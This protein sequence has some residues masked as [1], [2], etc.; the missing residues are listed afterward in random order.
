M[1][2]RAFQLNPE[3]LAHSI[4]SAISLCL[5]A[6]V[7]LYF[8]Y[9][10]YWWAMFAAFVAIQPNIGQSVKMAIGRFLGTW[11]GIAIALMIYTTYN[12]N[13]LY[14][15]LLITVIGSIIY[16]VV[17]PQ[18]SWPSALCLINTLNILLLGIHAQHG[19]AH[20]A[21]ERGLEV[22]L[23][24]TVATVVLIVLR[25]RYAH[26]T[27]Q[28]MTPKLLRHY[29]SIFTDIT[30]PYLHQGT[31]SRLYS[32]QRRLNSCTQ[33][34][35]YLMTQVE[36]SRFEVR[37]KNFN[38]KHALHLLHQ[39][40]R[41]HT[42]LSALRHAGEYYRVSDCTIQ[43]H[44]R[45]VLT[46][47]KALVNAKLLRCQQ[48]LTSNQTSV[49]TAPTPPIQRRATTLIRLNIARL[50]QRQDPKL[51]DRIAWLSIILRLI[52]QLDETEQMIIK[53][54]LSGNHDEPQVSLKQEFGGLVDCQTS[55]WFAWSKERA[56]YAC[57]AALT[58]TIVLLL[59]QH[60]QWSAMIPVIAAI[61]IMLTLIS[62]FNT[63][64]ANMG[65]GIAGAIAGGLYS[66]LTL[67]ILNHYP[68][69]T[70]LL[71]S[72]F[73]ATM[74]ASYCQI[75]AQLDSKPNMV[76]A[77]FFIMI[78][79]IILFQ[80]PSQRTDLD[81]II[82]M[83]FA[84]ILSVIVLA[85][86]S[87]W[88][89]PFSYKAAYKQCI[90]QQLTDSQTVLRKLTDG[91]I[92]HT[93]SDNVLSALRSNLNIADHHLTHLNWQHQ[94]QSRIHSRGRHI[95]DYCESLIYT[96]L[97]MQ[98]FYFRDSD[99]KTSIA[100][101]WQVMEPITQ[102]MLSNFS[103]LNESMQELDSQHNFIATL[104]Q[105]YLEQLQSY[106]DS[107]DIQPLNFDSV[108]VLSI[109]HLGM[110]RLINTQLALHGAIQP[111]SNYVS[112]QASSA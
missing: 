51:L 27:I 61:S 17:R 59:Q 100:G 108:I 6:C 18:I 70:L 10:D 23:A 30:D 85:T 39:F 21:L 110:R 72:L 97:M 88:I 42:I 76:F 44:D 68:Q 25:F 3:Y 24:I 107:G 98:V 101:Y 84:A 40:R 65:I 1:N 74:I 109:M 28:Q 69:G 35:N 15:P 79:T 46:E 53:L 36:M 99:T 104:Q 45:R 43:A 90:E 81:I 86:I 37:R 60:Y 71:I 58:F 32:I 20:F 49:N 16:F 22:S 33:H 13:W 91:E 31:P 105:D 48:L 54:R 26:Q 93:K 75:S 14:Y 2:K 64:F 106:L 87:R 96:L 83:P 67:V 57:Q 12:F 29:R 102:N 94:A 50:K 11:A 62:N 5:C 41:L 103:N 47:V 77:L 66:W 56:T 55:G 63:L 38:P 95:L 34:I 9:D 89:L 112:H 111:E 52:E 8:H 78:T 92:K 19:A 82:F 80:S 7:A 73:I 4:K